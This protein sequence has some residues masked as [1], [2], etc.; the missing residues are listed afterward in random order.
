[1]LHQINDHLKF[2]KNIKTCLV[3]GEQ[4]YWRNTRVEIVLHPPQEFYL[5]LGSLKINFT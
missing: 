5:L 2:R 1:M 4:F 3:S